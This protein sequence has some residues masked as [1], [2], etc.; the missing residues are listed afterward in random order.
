MDD[1]PGYLAPD[2]GDIPPVEVKELP[3]MR[4]L[5]LRRHVGPYSQV[6]QTWGRL[7]MWAGMRGLPGPGMQTIGIVHDDP[8]VTPPEK[9]RCDPG[10]VMTRPVQPEGG[11][12]TFT[13]EGP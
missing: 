2:Y 6:G 9:V 1:V 12:A 13:H 11:Y 5:F 7:T 10:V 3:P 4:L 8:D